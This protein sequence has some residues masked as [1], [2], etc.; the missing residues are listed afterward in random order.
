MTSSKHAKRVN[1]VSIKLIKESSTLYTG[2]KVSSPQDAADLLRVFL[3]D[4]DREKMIL[5]CLD[6]KNQPTAIHTI[7]IGSLASAIIH[8]RE[9]FKTAL[10]ANSASILIGH[11]HPSGDPLPSQE[12]VNITKR[13]LESGKILGIDLIDHIIIGDNNRFVSL[14]EKGII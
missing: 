13:L 2:R 11:Q 5:C 1:L 8:P 14:K 12:D 9:V 6:T 3:E 4:C 7:S 10:L